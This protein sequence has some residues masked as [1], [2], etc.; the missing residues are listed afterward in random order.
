MPRTA[1]SGNVRPPV[2]QRSRGG[3][4]AHGRIDRLGRMEAVFIGLMALVVLLTGYVSLL[5]LY[6]LFKAEN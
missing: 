4:G 6:K 1:A 3:R 2:R 5:V